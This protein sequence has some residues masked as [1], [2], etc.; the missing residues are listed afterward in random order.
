MEL[1]NNRFNNSCDFKN[2]DKH[3]N[4]N[5]QGQKPVKII[6]HTI[7]DFSNFSIICFPK[8]ILYS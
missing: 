6:K 4:T 8:C 2:E 1:R 3:E 7:N 5:K